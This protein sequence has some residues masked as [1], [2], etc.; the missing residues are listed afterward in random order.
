LY[1]V[2]IIVAIRGMAVTPGRMGFTL[3]GALGAANNDAPGSIG[4]TLA[5]KV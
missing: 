3:A 1:E 4:P 2:A 5:S